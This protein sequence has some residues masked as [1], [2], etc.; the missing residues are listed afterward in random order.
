MGLA[1]ALT[2]CCLLR[3]SQTTRAT[4]TCNMQTNEHELWHVLYP[5]QDTRPR[6]DWEV[7]WQRQVMPI[8]LH[9]DSSIRAGVGTTAHPREPPWDPKSPGISGIPA[10]ASGYFE[11]SE[12]VA[13][14]AGGNTPVAH[15]AW[16]CSQI[17]RP[18]T[19]D[20]PV[21]RSRV[22]WLRSRAAKALCGVC[23]ICKQSKQDLQSDG[24]MVPDVV[25]FSDRTS[26]VHVIYS[27][28]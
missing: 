9:A 8:R 3:C 16:H 2:L 13:S 27:L 15:E 1:V 6:L 25:H 17:I 19:G 26:A 22:L 11:N 23:A 20:A 28:C 24:Y 10:P 18:L 12:R 21:T 4:C 7:Q 14:F 5:A